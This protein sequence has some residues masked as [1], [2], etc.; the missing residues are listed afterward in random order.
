[1]IKIVK[2][3]VFGLGAL[4]VVATVVLIYG[5]FFYKGSDQ[6]PQQEIAA[7]FVAPTVS[8]TLFD[9]VGLSQ[10][11]GSTIASVSAQGTLVYV[12]VRGG[13]EADRILVVDLAQG[14]VLGRIDMGAVDSH[15]PRPAS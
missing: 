1:M 4:I 11:S 3:V 6:K 15:P 8:T 10:P 9:V 13:G 7:A 14:R 2:G 5:A 12:T